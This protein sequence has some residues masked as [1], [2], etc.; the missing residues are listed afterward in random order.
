MGKVVASAV[1]LILMGVALVRLILTRTVSRSVVRF[2]LVRGPWARM[3]RLAGHTLAMCPCNHV[4]RSIRPRVPLPRRY[5]I[6]RNRRPLARTVLFPS[7]R[8]RLQPLDTHGMGENDRAKATKGRHMPAKK[9]ATKPAKT[10]VK[11][12]VKTAAAERSGLEAGGKAPAFKLTRDDGSTV[13][14]NDFK[15]RNLVLYFYPKADTPGCTQEA[16]DFSRLRQAFAKADTDIL[17]VSADPIAAQAKFKGKHK[18]T[19]ALASDESTAMLEAYGAWGKK[20]MYGRTFLGVI[21]K[22]L[23]IDGK[24]RIARVWPIVKVPGHADEVLEAARG[25]VAG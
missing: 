16:M 2:A 15:G 24:G 14:L 25:L 1:P 20:S 6:L 12:A 11:K 18:L 10:P 13:S 9:P 3:M 5:A 4:R 8:R 7:G 21:R 17:G 19:I 22:T 23:L